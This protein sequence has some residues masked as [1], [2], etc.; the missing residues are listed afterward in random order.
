VTP[1]KGVASG[2]HGNPQKSPTT[3]KREQ[4]GMVK[5]RTLYRMVAWLFVTGSVI[6]CVVATGLVK[7]PQMDTMAAKV[8][9]AVAHGSYDVLIGMKAW[10]GT[11]ASDFSSH[12]AADAKKKAAAQKAAKAK[13]AA[14]D[15]KKAAADAAAKAAAK[16]AHRAPKN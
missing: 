9:T 3:P 7:Q 13:K 1:G 8:P 12:N 2:H 5:S 6:A 4:H 16:K 10:V 14:A 15:A 11:I